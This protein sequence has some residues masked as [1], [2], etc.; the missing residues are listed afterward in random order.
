MHI[1]WAYNILHLG[2][3]ILLKTWNIFILYLQNTKTDF[4][5][6]CFEILIVYSKD[7]SKYREFWGTTINEGDT[8]HK[9][10]LTLFLSHQ[11]RCVSGWKWQLSRGICSQ[12]F[13]SHVL[14]LC[15]DKAIA[16]FF[17]K[18]RRYI[19]LSLICKRKFFNRKVRG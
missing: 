2:K 4:A 5:N 9:Y 11:S 16:C 14:C 17:I 7:S 19:I 10:F 1:A 12:L 8:S 18:G 13:W 3:T 15:D 6:S